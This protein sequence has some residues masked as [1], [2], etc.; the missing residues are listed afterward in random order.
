MS[1]NKI[2]IPRIYTFK[3]CWNI[4][5]Y[6]KKIKHMGSFVQ[7]ILFVALLSS[8][9][10]ILIILFS[11]IVFRFYQNKI[12]FLKSKIQWF[13]RYDIYLALGNFNTFYWI[14]LYKNV[15]HAYA[16]FMTYRF[17]SYLHINFVPICDTQIS[18]E[19]A[20]NMTIIELFGLTFPL[21]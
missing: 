13:N 17:Q 4:I 14:L 16:I 8:V 3:S 18:N 15:F 1:R 10:F 7:F 12:L 2:S 5:Q 9:Y 20:W 19:L 6:S 21:D 11:L